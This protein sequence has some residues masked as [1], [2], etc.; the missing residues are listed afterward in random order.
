MKQYLN[1]VLEKMLK[2]QRYAP[3]FIEVC[4]RQ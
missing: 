4:V 2:C 1:P 3:D